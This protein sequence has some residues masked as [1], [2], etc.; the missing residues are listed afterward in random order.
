MRPIVVGTTRYIGRPDGTYI[1]EFYGL[2]V[3]EL[4]ESY[5]G[6]LGIVEKCPNTHARGSLRL[7]HSWVMV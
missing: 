7:P 4:F 3:Y 5:S 6:D 2:T 1:E